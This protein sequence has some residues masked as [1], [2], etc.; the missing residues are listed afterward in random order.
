MQPTLPAPLC[1]CPQ[2]HK[3]AERHEEYGETG[4]YEPWLK[5]QTHEP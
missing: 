2:D 1:P 5:V 4:Q 3:R